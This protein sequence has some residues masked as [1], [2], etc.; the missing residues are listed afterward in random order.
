VLG[1]AGAGFEQAVSRKK[2]QNAQEIRGGQTG[3]GDGIRGGVMS[4]PASSEDTPSSGIG[5]PLM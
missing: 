5:P 4:S 3:C 1:T 2:T